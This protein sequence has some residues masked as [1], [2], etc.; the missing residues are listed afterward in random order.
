MLQECYKGVTRVLQE[1]CKSVT[2]VLQECYK[3][4]IRVLQERYKGVYESSL[5]RGRISKHA[6]L[7]QA[8]AHYRF[9]Y[10]VNV[11]G[12]NELCKVLL[13]NEVL[14]SDAFQAFREIR[15]VKCKLCL[16][17]EYAVST[18][19]SHTHTAHFINANATS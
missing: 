4:V 6:Q 13:K 7:P 16:T 12:V 8:R 18:C 9:A 11:I 5:T 1:C 14:L 3:S 15:V 10:A 19:S 2:R 17:P